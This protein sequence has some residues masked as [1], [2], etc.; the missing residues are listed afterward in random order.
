MLDR[1]IGLTGPEPENAAHKPAAGE[2]RVERQRTVDQPYRGADVL[3]EYSQYKGGVGKDARVVL[4]RL[5]RLPR[6]I[7]GLAA[8]CLGLFG[9]SVI[10]EP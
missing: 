7:T 2:A 8:G 3:A 1:G 6:K 10:D 4:R 5:E 9:P